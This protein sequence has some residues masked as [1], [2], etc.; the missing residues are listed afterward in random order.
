MKISQQ[1]NGWHT[2]PEAWQHDHLDCINQQFI[3]SLFHVFFDLDITS[4]CKH[5][6]VVIDV[7][8]A[9]IMTQTRCTCI[10]YNT[11]NFNIDTFSVGNNFIKIVPGILPSFSQQLWQASCVWT[12]QQNLRYN[13][14]SESENNKK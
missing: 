7:N 12:S 10:T 5:I 9:L 2:C 1:K 4:A 6:L 11:I 14:M 3:S 13:E 8:S